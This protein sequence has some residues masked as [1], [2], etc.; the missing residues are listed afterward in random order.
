[1]SIRVLEGWLDDSQFAAVLYDGTVGQAWGPLFRDRDEAEAFLG[2]LRA[3]HVDPRSIEGWQ[4][5]FRL[6]D[7]REAHCACPQLMEERN[8]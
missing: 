6:K 4:L 1:M 8:R 7:F 5:A 2:F 3:R